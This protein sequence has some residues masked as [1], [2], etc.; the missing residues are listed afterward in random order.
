MDWG[1]GHRETG[2]EIKLPS[3]PYLSKDSLELCARGNFQAKRARR[4]GLST[5]TDLQSLCT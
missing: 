2:R 1:R 4:G 5:P 3:A